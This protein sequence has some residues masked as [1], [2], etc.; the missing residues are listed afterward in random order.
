M[1]VVVNSI[2]YLDTIYN[3]LPFPGKI[4]LRDLK[5]CKLSHIF[6]D[7]FFNIEKYLE[8]EQKDPFSVIRVSGVNRCH[9]MAVGAEVVDT[10]CRVL[11]EVETDGQEVSD[12]EKYAAEE[13][14]ILVAEE[15]ANEECN[16]V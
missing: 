8:H 11:Q 4:N 3:Y 10:T 13:Y 6:F 9:D 1:T 12:W 15:A 2:S 14:D 5:R 7:T 16:D